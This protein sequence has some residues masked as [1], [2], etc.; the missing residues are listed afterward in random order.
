MTV[1]AGE[2]NLILNYGLGN[3]Y[4]LWRQESVNRALRS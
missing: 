2:D 1:G 3:E 4:V